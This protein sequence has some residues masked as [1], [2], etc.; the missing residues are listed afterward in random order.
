MKREWVHCVLGTLAIFGLGLLVRPEPAAAIS[1]AAVAPVAQAAPA[2][3]ASEGHSVPGGLT[4]SNVALTPV[5][6]GAG[7]GNGYSALLV[8]V[9][10]ATPVYFGF[11][12]MTLANHATTGSK[13]CNDFAVCKIGGGQFSVN[14]QQ[15]EVFCHAPAGAT[16][17]IV[18]CV[19]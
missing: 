19:R 8:E 7:T 10:S 18:H 2:Q 9:E 3:L 1:P 15:G 4:C 14:V 17:V 6:C 13:R 16:S 12:E 5:R 11:E